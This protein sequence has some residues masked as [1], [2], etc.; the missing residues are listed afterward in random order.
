M[1]SL[2]RCLP[3]PAA[4]IALLVAVSFASA[5]D[6]RIATKIYRG[7]KPENMKV[8]SETTTL[9]LNGTV[10]DFLEDGTQIAV[11][12]QQADQPGRFILLNPEGRLQTEFTTD[13]VKGAMEKL[14]AFAARQ[15]K[16]E[17]KFAANP[18]FK[19][20]YDSETSKLVLA[21]HIETYT[22]ETQPVTHP[23]AIAEYREFLNW[24][25]QLN[26]LLGGSLP[27]PRMRLNEALARRR[28]IPETVELTHAEEKELTRAVHEYVYRL[29]NDDM[30][31]IEEVRAALASYRKVEN[32]EY[33][34]A[35]QAEVEIQR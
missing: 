19:E 5:E 24:Y 32:D 18:Q 2:V 20:S 17:L 35:E 14:R 25:T 1:V 31:R 26:G 11:F 12:R 30:N 29:K 27:E 9:F 13:K 23:E 7:T 8:V 16:P 28:A 34:K 15:D 21:S 10:Y 4:V 22:V 6:F 3:A 33:R